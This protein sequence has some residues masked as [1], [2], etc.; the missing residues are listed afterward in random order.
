MKE[1]MKERDV[2]FNL[3]LVHIITD[4]T[5]HNP[6]K[7]ANCILLKINVFGSKL[8]SYNKIHIECLPRSHQKVLSCLIFF[9]K[10]WP[11]INNYTSQ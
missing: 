10:H 6:I 4:F 5:Q 2:N 3:V 9:H 11:V 8:I 7:E 1:E